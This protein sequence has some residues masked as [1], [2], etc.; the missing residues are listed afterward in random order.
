MPTFDTSG[1]TFGGVAVDRSVFRE[2]LPDHRWYLYAAG[3]VSAG[4]TNTATISLR[5]VKDDAT[6]V[7]LGDTATH[8]TATLT[9]KELGPID[10]FA[11]AG[12]P[13]TENIVVVALHAIKAS[14]ANGTL[15]PW[16][17]WLRLLPRRQ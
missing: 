17:L 14:G 1:Q 10:L 9:K 11:E 15:G 8:S 12:V 4:D 16:T 3:M 5:Y 6:T 7:T 13:N 2:L